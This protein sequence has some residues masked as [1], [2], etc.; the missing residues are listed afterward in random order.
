MVEISALGSSVSRKFSSSYS[1][2]CLL[3]SLFTFLYFIRRLNGSKLSLYKL[4]TYGRYSPL[5]NYPSR[6]LFLFIAKRRL[7]YTSV[8]ESPLTQPFYC[9]NINVFRINT[10]IFI[11]YT[12]HNSILIFL[13]Y[14]FK[15]S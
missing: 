8:E 6:Y 13:Q 14:I 3:P 7:F 9:L 5:L 4:T 1:P 11:Y 12:H 15:L 2:I 10:K